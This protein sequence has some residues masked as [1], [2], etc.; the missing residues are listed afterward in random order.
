[1]SYIPV[2]EKSV[3]FFSYDVRMKKVSLAPAEDCEEIYNKR[4]M[5]LQKTYKTKHGRVI[6]DFEG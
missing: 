2:A 5:F 1:M 6:C 3:F 4:Y